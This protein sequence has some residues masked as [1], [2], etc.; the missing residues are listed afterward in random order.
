MSRGLSYE[1]LRG[2]RSLIEVLPSFGS[3][4]LK[5]GLLDLPGLAPSSNSGSAALKIKVF[6]F[7]RCQFKS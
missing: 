5:T 1:Q 3:A 2:C 7:K 4:G 6:C